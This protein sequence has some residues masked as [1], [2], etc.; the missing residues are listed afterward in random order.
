MVGWYILPVRGGA[1]RC[2]FAVVLLPPWPYFSPVFPR[3]AVSAGDDPA[4]TGAEAPGAA[5]SSEPRS[6]QGKSGYIRSSDA[7]VVGFRCEMPAGRT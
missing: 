4:D 3:A 7:E 6:L 1:Q 5:P 2:P